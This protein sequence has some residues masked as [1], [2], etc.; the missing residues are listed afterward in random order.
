MSNTLALSKNKN[1]IVRAGIGGV[2]ALALTVG[3]FALTANAD[4][5]FAPYDEENPNPYS[6]TEG[7]VFYKNA[8][9]GWIV[10]APLA[11]VDSLGYTVAD[12]TSYA[13]SFQLV[14]TADRLKYNNDSTTTYLPH[15]YTR[16][17]FEPYMQDAELGLNANTGAYTDLQ[18]GV[19]W[20]NKIPTGPGSQDNPQP[21]SFF[22]DGGAAGWDNV[23]V[24]AVDVHQGSTT[25]ATSV[26]TKVSYNGTDI[27]LGNADTT[28]FDQADLDNAAAAAVAAY[29]STHHTA[30]GSSIGESRALLS[31][32][33]TH[34]KVVG[35]KLTGS[36]ATKATAVKYQ[37]Y[38]SGNPVLG[39]TNATYK[40]PATAAGK[41][42]SVKVT[43]TY[44]NIVFGIHSNTLAAK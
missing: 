20:T 34:G 38:V 10:N 28:R 6:I 42:V 3:G 44:K 13:P 33:P 9:L 41:S 31:V 26:V 27:P 36:I 18:D 21:L 43:G 39:A 40:V 8:D 11:D 23:H 24:T 32:V 37:W 19:W 25:D 29:A 30:D 22:E 5:A 7:L 12:G 15:Q 1:V 2:A 35:V 14:A 17:V 16:L 4:S